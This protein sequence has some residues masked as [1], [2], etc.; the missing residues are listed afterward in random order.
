M[1]LQTPHGI[2]DWIAVRNFL[3]MRPQAGLAPTPRFFLS[4]H[5]AGQRCTAPK[6]WLFFPPA[7]A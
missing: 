3:A 4:N 2:L 5:C 1:V 7:A 6:R